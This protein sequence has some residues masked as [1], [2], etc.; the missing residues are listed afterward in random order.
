MNRG[1]II[2]AGC[3]VLFACI[4]ASGNTNRISRASSLFKERPGFRKKEAQILLPLLTNGMTKIQVQ[5][6]L[7]EP[8][9]KPVQESSSYLWDYTVF[10]ST[11]LEI[12]FTNEA[13][14]KAVAIGFDPEEQ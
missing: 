12:H 14:E 2:L 6:L 11:I 10:Y 9:H 1:N 8:T 13:V 3:I 4:V 7:G 5:Q